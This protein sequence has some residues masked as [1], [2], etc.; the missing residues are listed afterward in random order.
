M[1]L[2]TIYKISLIAIFSCF[3]MS[4]TCVQL[5]ETPRLKPEGKIYDGF[6]VTIEGD[7]LHGKLQMLSPTQNQVKIKF[8]TAEMARVFKAK[9]LQTYS[10]HVLTVNRKTKKE[11]STWVNYTKKKVER[12]PVPFGATEVLLQQLV[13]GEIS[14]YNYYIE[15]RTDNTIEHLVYIEKNDELEI[16]NKENYKE[17][18]RTLMEDK[19]EML[20]KVGTKGYTYKFLENTISEY[21]SL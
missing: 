21:N 5:A 3:F 20:E 7:T 13:G 17:L 15:N 2:T 18:L 6:V 16:V 1:K 14:L 11:I 9:E 8:I 4:M 10:F 12:P 19:A